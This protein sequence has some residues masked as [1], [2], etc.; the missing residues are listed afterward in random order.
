MIQRI[1][2]IYL[3]I[4]SACSF[5]TLKFSFFGGNKLLENQT[6]QWVAF[7]A[8]E[9]VLQMILTVAIGVAALVI[10]FLFKDRKMQLLLTLSLAALSFINIILYFNAK[11][12]FADSILAITSAI[13]FA[14]PVVLLLAAN[15]I[16]KD[17]KLVKSADRLR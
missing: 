17:E 2:S 9:S 14:M 11:S 12:N 3:L 13:H 6:K 10:I 8:M 7:N 4:A 15:S 5:L 1:Q 16:Y